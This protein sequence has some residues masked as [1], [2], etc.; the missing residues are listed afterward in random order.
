MKSKVFTVYDSKTQVFRAPF[1]MRNEGEA[2]RA[3]QSIANDENS[4]IGKYPEDFSLLE[5]GEYDDE[6]GQFDQTEKFKSYG[7]A[8]GYQRKP[9]PVVGLPLNNETHKNPEVK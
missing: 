2:L 4:E 1:H 3:W 8:A 5:I 9:A 7:T 6:T